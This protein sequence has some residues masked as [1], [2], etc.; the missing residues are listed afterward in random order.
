MWSSAPETD[1]S[2]AI[3]EHQMRMYEGQIEE[4]ELANPVPYWDGYSGLVRVSDEGLALK[5]QQ[6]SQ[7]HHGQRGSEAAT[8]QLPTPFA[9]SDAEVEAPGPGSGGV[10]LATCRSLVEA[11][12]LAGASALLRTLLA[13]TPLRR[14]DVV[15]S[16]ADLLLQAQGWDRVLA[17]TP[18]PRPACAYSREL[19]AAMDCLRRSEPRRALAILHKAEQ[20]LPSGD[21]GCEAAR[22][23]ILREFIQGKRHV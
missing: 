12:Q 18:S 16:A 14:V 9:S 5:L 4:C 11:G 21:G 22:L 8:L 10:L 20:S 13:S 3:M 2:D 6:A 23:E 15:E 7:R 17:A 1:E 19:Q